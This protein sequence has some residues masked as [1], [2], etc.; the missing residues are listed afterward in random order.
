MACSSSTTFRLLL[1]A[2]SLCVGKSSRRE[3]EIEVA[4]PGKNESSPPEDEWKVT[5]IAP[6]IEGQVNEDEAW[7]DALRKAKV[8]GKFI[9][10][11]ED[12]KN[13]WRLAF[14]YEEAI[15]TFG[16]KERTFHRTHASQNCMSK[17]KTECNSEVIYHVKNGK[18]GWA[19]CEWYKPWYWLSFFQRSEGC[20]K[21]PPCS[22]VRFSCIRDGQ[23]LSRQTLL[24][25]YGIKGSPCC[26]HKDPKALG[27]G[28]KA[29]VGCG[30]EPEAPRPDHFLNQP[31]QG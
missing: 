20:Y 22:S 31:S 17:T 25:T 30:T 2:S 12:K 8:A 27:S 15:C 1:V 4:A 10:E 28:V 23:S 26:K 6:V 16:Y 29:M 24:V 14:E 21:S 3:L 11:F 18:Y 9:Q 19:P 13:E 5:T 7:L